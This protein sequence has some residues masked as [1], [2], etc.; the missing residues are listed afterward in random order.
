M[1]FGAL[2]AAADVVDDGLGEGFSGLLG[3]LFF[4]YQLSNVLL[5]LVIDINRLLPSLSVPRRRIGKVE[6]AEPEFQKEVAL[7]RPS[8]SAGLLP[9]RRVCYNCV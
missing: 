7:L 4:V 2:V 3:L 5:V 6:R 9:A 1:R 8:R